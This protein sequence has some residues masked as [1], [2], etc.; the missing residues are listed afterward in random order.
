MARGK[1]TLFF[2]IYLVL[3]LY[4]I[5]FGFQF[6]KIPALISNLDKWIIFL[7][8]IFLILGGINFLRLK[9]YTP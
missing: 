8:G 2:I 3:G 5:N 1:G 9:K 4:F 7:G 6:I